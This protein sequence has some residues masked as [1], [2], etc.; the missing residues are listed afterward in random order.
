MKQAHGPESSD[1][2]SPEA[3]SQPGVTYCL[4]HGSWHGAWCWRYLQKE[5]EA[6]GHRT[7]AMDLPIDDPDARFDDLAEVVCETITDE[8]NTVVVAHSRM[9]NILPRIASHLAIRQAVYLCAGFESN[10]DF[11]KKGRSEAEP[12]K[13]PDDFIAGIRLYP[14][15]MRLYYYDPDKAVEMFYHDCSPDVA[16]WAVSQLRPGARP[17]SELPVK[18]WPNTPSVYIRSSGDRVL[19]PQYSIFVTRQLGAKAI[20]LEGGHSLFLSRPKELSDELLE[21]LV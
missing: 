6:K 18:S 1:E 5:L 15:D 8:H 14:K 11:G 20:C 16:N 12:K 2:A 13:Y 9:G 21:A 3:P 10:N 4:V 17:E 19:N 7:I